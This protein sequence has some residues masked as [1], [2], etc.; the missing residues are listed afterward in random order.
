MNKT[1]GH[2]LS[3]QFNTIKAMFEDKLLMESINPFYTNN[4]FTYT[5]TVAPTDSRSLLSAKYFN[6]GEQYLAIFKN[7]S[8]HFLFKDA[9]I[10]RFH[11]E[12]D[13]K[14]KL[15]SY[16]LHWFPCPFSSEFLSGFIE[17]GEIEKTSFFEYLDLIEEIDN[18]NY[19]DFNF[20]SPI[21]ID[22]EANYDGTKGSFHPSS[23]IHFQDTDTRAKTQNIFC[24]YRF[25]AFVIE[26]CY[27]THNYNFHKEENTISQEMINESS[28]WLKLRKVNNE[29]FGEKINTNL[30]F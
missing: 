13:D 29:E 8:F 11:Y 21:R 24:I 27:P 1:P 20:R 26:N 16:N 2:Y 12:F 14:Y 15:L 4:L 25:F 23:H 22:Y 10:A 5:N 18:F 17:E 30:F 7:R 3:Q 9:S 28:Y 6:S 19:K